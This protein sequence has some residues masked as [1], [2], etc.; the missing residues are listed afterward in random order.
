V[1]HRPAVQKGLE[2]VMVLNRG[3]HLFCAVHHYGVG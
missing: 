1:K 3:V 2:A